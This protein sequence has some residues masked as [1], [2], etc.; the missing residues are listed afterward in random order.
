MKRKGEIAVSNG[1]DNVFADL[2]LRGAGELQIKAEVT[3]QICGRLEALGLS[4]GLA[5][6]RLGVKPPDARNLALG[7]HTGLSLDRLIAILGDLDVEVE[8]VFRTRPRGR[9][10]A[11]RG[12]LRVTAHSR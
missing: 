5:A 2:G 9:K 4:P 1:G 8:I 3:R 12:T 7:R 6:K 10:S 11:A